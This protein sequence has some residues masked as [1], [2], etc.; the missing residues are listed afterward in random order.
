MKD[1]LI[2]ELLDQCGISG[3]PNYKGELPV[4][5]CPFHDHHFRSPSFSVNVKNGA[6]YCFSCHAVGNIRRIFY[7]FGL[8]V[9]DLYN[10]IKEP[11]DFEAKIQ[12]LLQDLEVPEEEKN[13]AD[14]NELKNYRFL[15][16]YL[17]KRGYTREIILKNK[18][19]FNKVNARVTI[20]LVYG[21][22]Y[23]GCIQRS[24]LGDAQ[25]KYMY[26]KNLQKSAILYQPRPIEL[27]NNDV[28]IWNEGS[29]DALR[30]AQYG[31]STNGMLGCQMSN[32][33]MRVF[34]S[35]PRT[36]ILMLDNDAPGIKGTLDVLRRTN[37]SDVYV[38]VYP[39][40]K[41]DP[42]ELTQQEYQQ[43]V[44]NAIPRILWMH[45]VEIPA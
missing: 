4:T 19:G 16:P 36:Q 35:D 12:N 15:H 11:G 28:T 9:S 1:D 31:Y 38:A 10:D 22:K 17:I 24:V 6:Y 32:I 30:G 20:P 33:Q 5:F 39:D 40:G 21:G 44:E 42:A 2:L 13:N 41:K 45:Q 8:D 29:L 25:P 26:P 14:P 3:R 18:V 23:Y 37:R 7:H 43:V 27:I 34:N